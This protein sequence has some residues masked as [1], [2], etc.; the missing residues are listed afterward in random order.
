MQK[1]GM[2]KAGVFEHPNIAADN[3]LCLQVL[4][5]IEKEDCRI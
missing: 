1:I 2:A 5:K 4:Y 3:L